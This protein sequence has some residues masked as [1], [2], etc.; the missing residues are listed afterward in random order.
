MYDMRTPV[1]WHRTF[2]ERKNHDIYIDIIP[3]G[4]SVCAGG[5]GTSRP[6]RGGGQPPP[7]C[8]Y[9][10]SG[11]PPLGGA[12][13]PKTGRKP[14]NLS[15]IT[16]T[17]LQY[18]NKSKFFFFLWKFEWLSKAFRIDNIGTCICENKE[19]MSWK[20]NIHVYFSWTIAILLDKN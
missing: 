20:L 7:H 3:G 10:R 12:G 1:L 8:W 11:R 2:R 5:R 9:V 19:W 13:S 14:S 17:R 6:D 4:L 15:D 18:L 16:Q